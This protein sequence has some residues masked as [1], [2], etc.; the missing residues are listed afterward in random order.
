MGVWLTMAAGSMVPRALWHLCHSSEH[1]CSCGD[2]GSVTCQRGRAG[3]CERATKPRG[4]PGHVGLPMCL[5]SQSMT[6]LLRHAGQFWGTLLAP[7]GAQLAGQWVLPVNAS[8]PGLA[9]RAGNCPA[10]G[11]ATGLIALHA[12]LRRRRPYTVV[13]FDEIEKA[14][15]DVFNMMLQILEDGRCVA[16]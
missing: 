9:R 6:C 11:S 2:F 8:V 4:L 3:A 12:L 15:P 16:M 1:G 13:L 14:H 5:P 10:V 7:F